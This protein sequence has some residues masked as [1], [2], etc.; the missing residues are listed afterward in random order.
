MRCLRTKYLLTYFVCVGATIPGEAGVGA[1]G[2]D[3]TS[4]GAASRESGAVREAVSPTEAPA[5]ARARG[6]SGGTG[7]TST[8]GDEPAGREATE[9]EVYSTATTAHD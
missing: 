7:E 3:E 9:R 1:G 2:R 5:A 8:D 4:G 6:R